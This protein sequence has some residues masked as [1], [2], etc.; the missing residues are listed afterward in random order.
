MNK[1]YLAPVG[2]KI[3]TIDKVGNYKLEHIRW[4]I[5]GCAWR[6]ASCIDH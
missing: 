4:F 3:I 5:G 2:L 1:Y 6:A